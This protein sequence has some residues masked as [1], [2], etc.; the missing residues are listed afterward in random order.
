MQ[1][2]VRKMLAM[3]AVLA[4]PLAFWGWR[5]RTRVP[6]PAGLDVATFAVTVVSAVVVLNILMR[7]S[8][9]RLRLLGP[10]AW[11][12]LV[13]NTAVTVWFS[14]VESA[15]IVENCPDCG[16]GTDIRQSRVFSVITFRF[17]REFPTARELIASDL[18]IPC[19]H[20][21]TIR[22]MRNRLFGW[23]LW[24]ENF[25][26]IHRLGDRPWY[27]PCARDA[28]RSWA[29]KDPNFIRDFQERALN[30]RDAG[31]MN[32]LLVRLYDACPVDQLPADAYPEHRQAAGSSAP[33]SGERN[34]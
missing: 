16:H 20:K 29:T 7:A 22:W 25:R 1:L 24:G 9:N 21:Q 8:R 10:V 23:C 14:S 32:T 17:A 11:G 12:L 26:G 6:F 33:L 13:L 18:G 15:F 19:E 27:P 3:I 2:T 5:L 28:V 30:G 34:R 4:V 31:Y